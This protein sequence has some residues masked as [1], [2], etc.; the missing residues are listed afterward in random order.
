MTFVF[1]VLR[2]HNLGKRAKN[3]FVHILHKNPLYG[4]I[5]LIMGDFRLKILPGLAIITSSI[6]FLS[7]VLAWAALRIIPFALLRDR[8]LN[9]DS[10][11]FFAQ[12]LLAF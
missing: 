5:Q 7:F 2:N 11:Y 8:F 9:K 3:V 4:G 6:I 1:H 10:C 12:V